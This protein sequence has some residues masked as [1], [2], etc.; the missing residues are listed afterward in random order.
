MH[1]LIQ[2]PCSAISSTN[3]ARQG[4]CRARRKPG[5]E[6]RETRKIATIGL[7]SGPGNSGLISRRRPMK[8]S[9]KLHLAV[10]A[11]GLAVP[12]AAF[13][14]EGGTREAPAKEIL[15]PTADV[16]L[17]EQTLIGAP[18]P[19][20]WNDHP[21]DAAAWKLLIKTRADQIIKTL[22]GMREKFG[23]T[24]EQVTIAGVNCYILTPDNIPEQNRDRLLVH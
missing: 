17:Q 8:T 16:S 4:C 19:P 5:P 2:S 9:F 11:V 7:N 1:A 21:K 20:F 18:L 15:V 10:L 12:T 23:V 13:S 3:I 14:L 24:S 22:P 6:F